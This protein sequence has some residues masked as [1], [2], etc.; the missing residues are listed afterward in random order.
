M[1]S[2]DQRE[3]AG[4]GGAWEEGEGDKWEEERARGWKGE[5]EKGKRKGT[6]LG[7]QGEGKSWSSLLAQ[8]DVSRSQL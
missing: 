2:A 3:E 1:G 5:W 6:W 8:S 4:G 7:T